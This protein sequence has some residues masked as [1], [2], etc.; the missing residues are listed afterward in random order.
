L[1]GLAFLADDILAQ[2]A[3]ALAL[4]RL[5]R[6]LGAYFGGELAH[7]LLVVAVDDDAARR[8][9]FDGDAVALAHDNLMG[10]AQG[11]HKVLA[12]LGGAVADALDLQLLG[13]A[14]G[15]TVDHVG[16]EGPGQ[17]VQASVLLIVGGPGNQ[18][19]TVFYCNS[20]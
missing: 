12:L 13:V 2:I 16:D 17:A 7:G 11:H 10:V 15:Y 3:D 6:T 20:Q 5:R 9:D 19:L 4:I 18:D 1:A 14:L 8:G